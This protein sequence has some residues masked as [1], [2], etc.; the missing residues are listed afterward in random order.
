VK[1]LKRRR[2]KRV[3][4]AS[5]DKR[6]TARTWESD[7]TDRIFIERVRV[8]RRRGR[9]ILTWQ[10]I[11]VS[12][13]VFRELKKLPEEER[14]G[15]MDAI[16]EELGE[17]LW[18]V[19]TEGWNTVD[20][21]DFAG[22]ADMVSAVQEQVKYC[23]LANPAKF[24]GAALGLTDLSLLEAIAERVPLPVI[25]KSLGDIKHYAEIAGIILVVL[26]GGHILACT[27][28][29]L[30]VH[31]KLFQRLGQLLNNFFRGLGAERV[32]HPSR[33][34]A[35]DGRRSP[36]GDEHARP[37]GPGSSRD[38][39]DGRNE[40]GRAA[41]PRQPAAE[42]AGQARAQRHGERERRGAATP[43]ERQPRPSRAERVEPNPRHLADSQP[44]PGQAAPPKSIAGDIGQVPDGTPSASP[45]P[46]SQA[47]DKVRQLPTGDQR[48]TRRRRTLEIIKNSASEPL[49]TPSRPETDDERPR[50]MSR[51]GCES[52]PP[53]SRSGDAASPAG[54]KSG[55]ELLPSPGHRS[56]GQN[57]RG[58]MGRG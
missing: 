56:T 20:P 51:P 6:L 33:A 47:R 9:V 1:I 13:R 2:T 5:S 31:D 11:S 40:Q 39:P 26:T 17:P 30:W 52:T 49:D 45:R 37:P 15:V 41:P 10:V 3:F 14:D 54:R 18:K 38:D 23:L 4:Y 22:L 25:D 12:G 36:P 16:A 27:S 43:S 46:A 24:A 28:F 55:G 44:T 48:R 7:D 32:E 21:G 42:R 34:D 19:L 29:K 53:R 8:R 57:Q 58:G 50:Q 35:A